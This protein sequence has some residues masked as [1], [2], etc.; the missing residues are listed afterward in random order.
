[1]IA[2]CELQIANCELLVANGRQFFSFIVSY[3]SATRHHGA[4]RSPAA[5]ISV[6]FYTI[7]MLSIKGSGAL[8][9]RADNIR[10][11][12]F[13]GLFLSVLTTSL[14][15]Q[16]NSSGFYIADA[17]TKVPVVDAALSNS[18][19]LNHGLSDAR[20]F[21]PFSLIP[22]TLRQLRIYAPGFAL[23]TLNADSVR[24]NPASVYYLHRQ[25]TSLGEVT[26]RANPGQSILKT[27][28]DLDIH[29]RPINNS[30]EVLRM[31]PG[32]FIGQHA[33]GGKAEQLFLR[34]FDLDHG[35][36]INITVDGLPVNMVSHAHGQGYADLH[37]VIPELIEKVNFNKGPYFA[38][39]GNLTTAGYVEFKTRNYLDRD[40]VRLEAGQFG[41]FR[42]IGGLNL[43]PQRHSPREQS[44]FAAVEASY[45]QGYFDAKQD[46]SRYNGML[47]YHG[48]V[49]KSGVLTA[50]ATA[51]TSG[52]KASG[53]VPDRAV[54]SGQIGFYGAIDSTEGGRTSRGNASIE[55]LSTLRN[56]ASLLNRIFY[57][58]NQF[59]LYSNF[60]FFL[61][62][63][64]NGDQ[65]RQKENRNLYGYQSSYTH[66][67]HL[68]KFASES[69]LGLQL[70][71]DQIQ[72]LELSRT[73]NRDVT[74]DPMMKGK[75]DEMNLGIYG[76]Q[77]ISVTP[78]LDVTAGLRGDL[79]T[80]K[81]EDEIADTVLKSKT[82]IASPKLQLQYSINRNVQIYFYG[83][84]GFH[85]NDTRVAVLQEGRKVAPA[86]WGSD[87]GGVFKV[88][89]RMVLQ[90]ALWYLWLDQEFI[91][92][93]DEGVVEPGGASRRIGLDLSARY[94]LLNGLYADVDLSLADPR[95]LGVQKAE[96]YLPLAPRFTS[97]GGL[98]YRR[99]RGW[100]GSLRYRYMGGRPANEDYSVV[101]KGY[102]I[103]DAAVNY[104]MKNWE[105]GISVQNLFNSTWKETQ[106]D[107][108]SRLKNEQ[109]SVSEIHFTPGTPFFARFSVSMYF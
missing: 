37:W 38:D 93:G 98:T 88:G 25:L 50:T 62:D 90:S 33:G 89:K 56:G 10:K 92:V 14:S 16:T 78:K 68:G 82:V 96:S 19:G 85:S 104:T 1:M 91:Y 81:Y 69:N 41:T 73:K 102:F 15:A 59:E 79:F 29:L 80:N 74:T 26:V 7:H 64:V 70:R 28:S 34:G 55:L 72:D 47:R 4:V 6:G 8:S 60:T 23:L 65:I 67:Y 12:C 86:A 40:F 103:V 58:R 36:D 54:E 108:E 101:A 17:E 83:G 21:V 100:N 75:V 71:Y 106:F 48:S 44:L 107:T 42:A 99:M 11:V 35:T 9:F 61:V 45:T 66:R 27:I 46:F 30:Q 31:I 2:N 105:A 39:K 52:W 87:L 57:T 5:A 77:R 13:L 76:Q 51:F 95:A 18:G 84:R 49:G 53:Q 43:P 109:A 22:D 24:S 32:L 3:M 97:T 20:G 63:S 94:E